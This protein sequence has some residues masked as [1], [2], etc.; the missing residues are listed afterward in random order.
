M[1]T[2][3]KLVLV[4]S[5]FPPGWTGKPD[6][7]TTS[8]EDKVGSDAFSACVGT[9]R[10]ETRTATWTG[11]TFS[12]SDDEVSSE[13]NVASDKAV[14][15]KDVDAFKSPKLG[16]CVK[17]L[18]TKLL[19][20]QLGEAP[21]SFEVSPLDVAKHGDATVGIRMTLS[22]GPPVNDTFY[23]DVVFIGKDRAEVTSTFS[24]VGQPMDA[25]LQKSLIDKQ[26]ARLNA[27]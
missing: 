6:D 15:R 16:D 2:A 25:A 8:P 12:M 10:D 23:V 27:V 9:G 24:S 22:L 20:E 18:F 14:Y 4:A 5:D 3:K 11:D 19:T 1:E 17:T 21:T 26:G 13:T 7:Q